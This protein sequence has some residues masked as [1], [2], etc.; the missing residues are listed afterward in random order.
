MATCWQ[1]HC[2]LLGRP[3]HESLVFVLGS[4]TGWHAGRRFFFF[5][6]FCFF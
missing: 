4:T 3:T 6:L 5:V 2:L 1:R